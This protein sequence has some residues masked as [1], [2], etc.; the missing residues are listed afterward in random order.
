MRKAIRSPFIA[1]ALVAIFVGPVL[2][3]TSTGFSQV[4]ASRGTL[5][6]RVQANTPSA[7]LSTRGAVDIVTATVTLAGGATSGWHTHPGIVLVTVVSGSL[8]FFDE[9][10]QATVH[11]AGSAFVESGD[12]AGLVHNNS[13]TEPTIVNATYIVPVG[14][15]VLRIDKPNP[16]CPE[17]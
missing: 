13:A 4:I 14:T 16:G 17:S 3:T 9:H 1:L 10:C 7:K 12:D 8:T 2:A 11:A 5:S 6:Q 15:T